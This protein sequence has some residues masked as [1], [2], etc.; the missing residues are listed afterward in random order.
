MQ[1]STAVDYNIHKLML[2]GMFGNYGMS[3]TTRGL[4]SSSSDC[5]RNFHLDDLV[6]SP[7]FPDTGLTGTLSYMNETLISVQAAWC[8]EDTSHNPRSL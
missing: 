8:L 1:V 3:W 5:A 2:T 4:N 7:C 6:G